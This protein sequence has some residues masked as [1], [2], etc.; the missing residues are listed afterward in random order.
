MKKCHFHCIFRYLPLERP[1][2][3]ACECSRH[4]FSFQ[5]ILTRELQ[6]ERTGRYLAGERYKWGHDGARTRHWLLHRERISKY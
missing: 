1:G 5:G 4:N 2:G 3:L 6:K